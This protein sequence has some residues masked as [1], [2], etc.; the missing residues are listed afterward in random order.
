MAVIVSL[1]TWHI[2]TFGVVGTLLPRSSLVDM[3]AGLAGMTSIPYLPEFF[4]EY[5]MEH[6][7]LLHRGC[8][9]ARVLEAGRV[10]S[11]RTLGLVTFLH[12]W[13]VADFL[14]SLEPHTWLQG[15]F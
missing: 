5:F 8:T 7:P 3:I 14:I 12:R 6:L 15:Y 10:S 2:L 1:I 9:T 4:M 11:S 13:S